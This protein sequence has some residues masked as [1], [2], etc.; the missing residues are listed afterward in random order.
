MN[1]LRSEPTD[2][3]VKYMMTEI[4]DGKQTQKAVDTFRPIVKRGFNQYISD[5]IRETLKNAMKSQSDTEAMAATTAELEQMPA[6]QT[7]ASQPLEENSMAL[8]HGEI[9]AFAIVKSIV[10]D[11][12]D[13][14]RLAH[15]NSLNYVAVLLDDNK[16][17][18]ICRFWFKRKQKYIT[19]PD[20][21][22]KPVRY[23]IANIN[24][25]YNYADLI[26]VSCDRYLSKGTLVMD[27]EEEE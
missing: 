22:K 15:R 8:T 21:N 9:E 12:C 2:S 19:I 5:N 3:F 27:D 23:D 13:I 11:L 1:S 20:E 26:K 10:R 25:I 24:D 17:K 16:L 14:N 4:Y 7:V 18:R 6:A